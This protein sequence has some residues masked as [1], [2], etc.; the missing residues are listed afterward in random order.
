[1]NSSALCKELLS[2]PSMWLT[3]MLFSF[4]GGATVAMICREHPVTT[5]VVFTISTV[6]KLTL[7]RLAMAY[8]HSK[9]LSGKDFVLIKKICTQLNMVTCIFLIAFEF[10]KKSLGPVGVAIEAFLT[11]MVHYSL[12]IICASPSKPK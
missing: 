6:A 11:G 8:A 2:A 1:M 5:G 3:G 4:A 9:K 7:L 12:P 10:R